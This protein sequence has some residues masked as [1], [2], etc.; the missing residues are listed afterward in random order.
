LTSV[1]GVVTFLGDLLDGRLHASYTDLTLEEREDGPP[2]VCIVCVR[3]EEA[4]GGRGFRKCADANPYPKIPEENSIDPDVA[5]PEPIQD[6]GRPAGR[7]ARAGYT[8]F[9]R[10]TSGFR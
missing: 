5:K 9:C 3:A 2:D 7:P 1:R 6:I 8:S 4:G 10:G